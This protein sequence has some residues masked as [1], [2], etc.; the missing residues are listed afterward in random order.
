M[1]RKTCAVVLTLGGLSVPAF[2]STTFDVVWATGD[3]GSWLD[4]SNLP[5]MF[6]QVVMGENGVVAAQVES[7]NG[8]Q[9]LYSSAPG[10][11]NTTAVAS[12]GDP[13]FNDNSGATVG[14]LFSM[15]ISSNSPDGP[16]LTFLAQ[17][18]GGVSG[19]YRY[20]P[21]TNGQLTMIQED[22]STSLTYRPT[23]NPPDFTFS[24]NNVGDLAIPTM[25]TSGFVL[26]RNQ[27]SNQN[28]VIDG[29]TTDG[30]GEMI[31]GVGENTSLDR[32]YTKSVFIT[33]GDVVF[34]GD[35]TISGGPATAA[36]VFQASTVGG[37]VSQR[38]PDSFVSNDSVAYTAHYLIGANATD[39]LVG[40]RPTASPIDVNTPGALVFAHDT[41]SGLTYQTLATYGYM[42]N[43]VFGEVTANGYAAI[44]THTGNTPEQAIFASASDPSAMR[45]I[46]AGVDTID[47]RIISRVGALQFTGEQGAMINEAGLVVLNAVLT[48]PL[49]GDDNL[50]S[51][52]LWNPLMDELSVVL[53]VGDM[54]TID[55]NSVEVAG[56]SAFGYAGDLLDL[57]KDALSEDGRLAIGIDYYTDGS[58][59]NIAEALLV[60]SVGVPEPASI[61]LMG[62]L[63]GGLLAR[64]RRMA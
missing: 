37:T 9:I 32:R 2:G 23:L 38:L 10:V 57:N 49:N 60:T 63:A 35:H 28:L 18:D 50:D 17:S 26:V 62:L 24:T 44:V 14:G 47:G 5:Y 3:S 46:T 48:D 39:T 33:G 43:P 34:L 15:A 30:S 45:M 12:Y 19:I 20:V 27:G 55:G 25:Q 61:G 36:A 31:S 41:G 1:F 21:A 40:A 52:L 53:K 64:R 51:V 58:H 22:A 16:V 13:I 59:A 56:I 42:N 8:T 54:V 29:T 11:I 6:D 4:P 7:D